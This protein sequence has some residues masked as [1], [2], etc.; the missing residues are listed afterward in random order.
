MDHSSYLLDGY[1]VSLHKSQDN[2]IIEAENSE[3][4]KLYKYTVTNQALASL[5]LFFI[6]NTNDLQELLKVGFSKTD[7]NTK[8]S[9]EAGPVINLEATVKFGK[10]DRK[11]TIPFKLEEQNIS[12]TDNCERILNALLGEGANAANPVES[13]IIR[14]LKGLVSSVKKNEKN[15]ANISKNAEQKQE[16]QGS[17]GK[18]NEKIVELE[19]NINVRLEE[20]EKKA[21]EAK[22]GDIEGRF[23]E[24]NKRIESLNNLLTN[25]SRNI[26][27]S[28]ANEA[29]LQA[30]V[31]ET[32]S[33]VEQPRHKY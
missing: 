22:M 26:S 11:S 8:V 27:T 33:K 3:T 23:A 17:D 24:V 2:L 20:I 9:L 18:V 30:K 28:K 31:D 32:F 5:N 15:I 13:Q 7:P 1:R 14:V 19:K 10:A 29:A 25:I 16:V 12:A 21:V 4:D 6:A